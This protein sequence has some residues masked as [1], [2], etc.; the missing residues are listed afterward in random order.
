PHLPRPGASHLPRH[1]TGQLSHLSKLD[2]RTRLPRPS[3]PAA[4]AYEHPARRRRLTP[5]I[6]P[7]RR[8]RLL[9]PLRLA[10]PRTPRPDETRRPAQTPLPP[11]APLRH[12]PRIQRRPG[13]PPLGRSV[14]A[15]KTVFNELTSR[16][17]R[18]SAKVD[19]ERGK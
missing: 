4:K 17:S 1:R 16:L 10:P 3:A 11:N 15:G 5:P 9:R 13:L 8:P 7:T 12:A 14:P 2:R 19:H 6:R 18:P